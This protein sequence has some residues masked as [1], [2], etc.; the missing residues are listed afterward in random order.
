MQDSGPST[1]FSPTIVEAPSSGIFD[2]SPILIAMIGIVL[3]CAPLVYVVRQRRRTDP[4][5]LAFRTM[6]RKMGFTHSQ[7]SA[8]RKHASA[9]GLGSPIGVL[10]SH[11]LTAQ[12]FDS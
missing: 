1:L 4:R 6:T 9:L 5:E 10:M 2:L 12:A 11:E 3:I 8:L 7:S